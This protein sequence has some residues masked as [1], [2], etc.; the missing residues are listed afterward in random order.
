M[1]RLLVETDWFEPLSP[2]SLVDTFYEELILDRAG[3]LF[4]GFLAVRHHCFMSNDRGAATPH[5]ALIDRHYRTWWLVLLQAGKSPPASFFLDQAEIVRA[6][7]YSLEDAQTLADRNE[8]IEVAKLERL[9][10][11][12]M[13]KLYVILHHPP[14]PQLTSADIRI[15]IAELFQASGGRK[16]LRINGEHP[17]Q[18]ED[19]LG[20]CTRDPM[21]KK[22]LRFAPHAGALLGSTTRWEIDVEGILTTWTIRRRGDEIWLV[23]PTA[24]SL[25]F[26]VDLFALIR[27]GD[28][29]LQM[30]P[31]TS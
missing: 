15:G 18:P 23:Q 29:R 22:L 11:N 27:F 16:I 17:R 5:L 24:V 10:K 6:H 13:P 25:P 20:I 9:M 30:V 31:H 21:V 2:D 19:R 4:P 3:L 12:E 14:A 28:G 1:A 8:S 7:P 26:D